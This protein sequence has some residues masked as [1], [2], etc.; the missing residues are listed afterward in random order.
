MRT[1]KCWVIMCQQGG[2]FQAIEIRPEMVVCSKEEVELEV[3]RLN[4]NAKKSGK[5][6]RRYYHYEESRLKR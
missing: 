1:V 2:N 4:D 6:F 3:K 5:L